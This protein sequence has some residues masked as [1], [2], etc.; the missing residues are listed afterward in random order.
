MIK[1]RTG[2]SAMPLAV[3][4]LAMPCLAIATLTNPILQ[5]GM[6]DPYIYTGLLHDTSQILGRYGAT[7][8]ANR[9]AFT[10]PAGAAVAL[11]GDRGGHFLFQTGYLLAATLSGFALGRRYFSTT[12]G[13]A[14]AAWV[15]FNPWLIRA[16]AWDYIEGAAVCYMSVAFCCFGLNGRRPILL[17]IAGGVVFAL[18][19]NVDPFVCAM[20]AAFAP[21]WLVLNLPRGILH[22]VLCAA[23]ALA[24]FVIG[25]AGLLLA[26]YLQ[27]PALGFAREL[28]TFGMAMSLLQGGG[29][30]WFHPMSAFL[31]QGHIYII[32]PAFLAVGLT[33]LIVTEYTARQQVDRFSIAAAICLVFT[34]ATYVLFHSYLH[35]TILTDYTYD[36]YALPAGMLTIIALLGNC[37]RTLSLQRVRLICAAASLIFALLW[38]A[39]ALWHPLLDLM[40]PSAFAVIAVGLTILIAIARLPTLRSSAALMAAAFAII[41]FYYPSDRPG[42]HPIAPKNLSKFTLIANH[43]AALHDPV[44]QAPDQDSYRG[45]LFLQ[46]VIAQAVPISE[47]PV[48]F[49]YGSEP[50]DAPF[51]S[52]QSIFLWGYS[53]ISSPA[54]PQSPD[55]RLSA[56]L[57]QE[58]ARYSHIAILSRTEVGGDIAMQALGADGAVASLRARYAYHGRWFSFVVTI[59]DYVPSAGPVG[60]EIAQIPLDHLITQNN[61][62]LTVNN[63]AAELLTAPGQWNYSAM[64]PLP[65]PELPTGKLVVR[66]RLRVVRGQVGVLVTPTVSSPKVIEKGAGQ[67]TVPRDVDLTIPI[68]SAEHLVVIRN[69]AP[70]GRSLVQIFSIAIFRAA[71]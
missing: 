47:G 3:L 67:T 55:E 61:A 33:T 18:A 46:R 41:V 48:G 6:L 27:M 24:A 23:A 32:M 68:G 25:Y 15:A 2:C 45:A 5:A 8:Y 26:E 58:L 12:V 38:V 44:W 22:C 39:Y 10:M 20:A 60:A 49:W 14:A 13:I 17:H 43:Y 59:V 54:L 19:C 31:A 65:S 4:L 56:G 42:A 62:T 64:A 30:V 40:T 28:T 51:N 35:T 21:A 36:G 70:S 9:V 16:L 53:R 66:V 71:S 69:W 63:D 29:A 34:S 1:A 37:T 7:Y 52:I 11:L 50:Q 57:R